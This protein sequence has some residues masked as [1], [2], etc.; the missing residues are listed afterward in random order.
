MLDSTELTS[1]LYGEGMNSQAN[2]KDDTLD[3]PRESISI[4]EPTTLFPHKE[5]NL[6]PEI[7]RSMSS[8]NLETL[9][10]KHLNFSPRMARHYEKVKD[11]QST[12]NKESNQFDKVEINDVQVNPKK[13][14]LWIGAALKESLKKGYIAQKLN[15]PKTS[16]LKV[17]GIDRQTLE[18]SEL[19]QDDINRLY[20][21]LYVYSLGFYELTKEALARSQNQKDILPSIWKVYSVLLQYVCKT[22]YSTVVAQLTKAYQL[23]V[24]RLDEIIEKNKADYERHRDMLELKISNL[25][26]ENMTLSNDL[27]EARDKIEDLIFENEKLKVNLQEEKKMRLQFEDKF[28]DIFKELNDYKSRLKLTSEE[29]TK[30]VEDKA[31]IEISANLQIQEATSLA[32]DKIRLEKSV[33]NYQAECLQLKEEI[34]SKSAII[35]QRDNRLKETLK[36]LDNAR[37]EIDKL[38]RT[39]DE[40]D[41]RIGVIQSKIIEKNGEKEAIEANLEKMKRVNV[42]CEERIRELTNSLESVTEKYKQVDSKY[43]SIKEIKE[44]EDVE[45][46]TLKTNCKELQKKIELFDSKYWDYDIKYNNLNDE[47]NSIKKDYD[48][49]IKALEE[50]NKTRNICNIYFII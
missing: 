37:R 32:A 2:L 50:V 40:K 31:S 39:V 25:E 33:S 29:L 4:M 41:I 7:R 18:N 10:P 30:V 21:A 42:N 24:I 11:Y 5:N 43:Q 27:A 20:R 49:C 28:S 46:K 13:I 44:V 23:D 38:K 48:E 19:E 1:K 12:V 17:F 35:N 22:E 16:L 8:E 47:Y 9:S 36:E 45:L 14:E 3:L 26:D 15:D 34:L 6:F